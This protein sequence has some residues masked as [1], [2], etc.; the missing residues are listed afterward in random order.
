MNKPPSTEPN[1]DNAMTPDV[2]ADIMNAV[3]AGSPDLPSI[4]HKMGQ[5]AAVRTFMLTGLLVLASLYTLY[6][7]R[8]FFLP[9]VI[10]L[11]L[12]FLLSPPLRLMRNK[13]RIPEKLG[14]ALLLLGMVAVLAAGVYRLA[15]PAAHW[16][17]RAPTVM[18]EIERKLAGIKKPVETATRAANEVE[19][20]ADMS[21]KG[22][23]SQE[24]TVKGPSF[25]K[26]LFGGTADLVSNIFFILFLTY[27]LLAAGDLFLQKMIKVL[28]QFRDKKRAVSIARETEEQISTY[29]LTSFAIHASLGTA[30]GIAAWIIG[31]PNPILWGVITAFLNI[32]PY[33]GPI[34]NIGVLFLAGLLTFDT[35]GQAVIAP[36]AFLMLNF[37]EANVI[38]PTI[39]ADRM[40][41]NTVA[42]F[43]GITFWWF[44]WGI[45]GAILAVPLM[46]VLKIVC[47][48]VEVLRPISEFLSK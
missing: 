18:P 13:L 32:V 38:T 29:I 10:A 19:E 46:A 17:S 48:H 12:D 20:A 27:F 31:L 11:L 40:A 44:L 22:D 6:A 37:L 21:G 16:M 36:A 24:V 35:P 30:M 33:I 26:R 43:V 45:P 39:M 28:P 25:S 23:K 9:V 8:S 1:D 15:S 14:A 5:S 34:I 3:S 47:D 4:V 41:L 42:V 2:P 7:A